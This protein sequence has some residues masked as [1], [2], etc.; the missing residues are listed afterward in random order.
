MKNTRFHLGMFTKWIIS[1]SL[2]TF[3]MA[4]TWCILFF[5]LRIGFMK[6]LKELCRFILSFSVFYSSPFIRTLFHNRSCPYKRRKVLF[7]CSIL[8]KFDVYKH[9]V[10]CSAHNASENCYLTLR[11]PESSHNRGTLQYN[12]F[13]RCENKKSIFLPSFL[14]IR[15]FVCCPRF[16]CF[17][18]AP[19][20]A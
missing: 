7:L 14:L 16:P 19:T 18:R 17:T 2:I 13:I 1:G 15:K 4:F 20:R 8:V 5:L 9:S 3:E 6:Y 12:N 11:S 10:F